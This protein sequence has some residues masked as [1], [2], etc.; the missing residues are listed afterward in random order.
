MNNNNDEALQKIYDIDSDED[1]DEDEALQSIDDKALQSI[2]DNDKIS[3][4]KLKKLHKK[5][6]RKIKRY[7]YESCINYSDIRGINIDDFKFLLDKE[8]LNFEND[9]DM[10]KVLSDNAKKISLLTH[11]YGI[12]NFI[13]ICLTL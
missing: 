2:D 8:E 13:D 10:L 11:A 1:T 4:L 5:Y 6:K 9:E 3:K 12:Y 7:N